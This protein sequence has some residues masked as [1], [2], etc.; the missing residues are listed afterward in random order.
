[1]K[2][3]NISGYK[4]RIDFVF[5]YSEDLKSRFG[6]LEKGLFANGL[7]M[8]SDIWKPDYLKSGQIGILSKT[9]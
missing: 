2:S 6:T 7:Q 4:Y 5:K 1:M 3:V 9:I 8:G